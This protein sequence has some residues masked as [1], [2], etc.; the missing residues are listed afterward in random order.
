M[1]LVS[2]SAQFL[3]VSLSHRFNV[4]LRFALLIVFMLAVFPLVASAGPGNTLGFVQVDFSVPQTPQTSVTVAYTNAQTAGDLNVVV[5]GWN[6]STAKISSVTDSNGNAYVLAVG[7]TVQSGTATQAIYYAKN[8]AAAAANNNKVKVTF[9]MRA[10]FP[11]VRIAEY[12]G[13]DPTAPV[14]VV[15]AAQGTT[16]NSNSGS[17]TTTSPNDLLVGANLVQGITSGPGPGYT[18]RVITTQDGDILEDE[19]VTTVGSYSATAPN[20][21]AWIMQMV[22]FRAAGSGLGV[23]P[24][25]TSANNT[26]FAVGA[27]GTFTVTTMGTPTPSLTESGALPSG[28]TFK[29]NGNGTGT[30]SGTPASG[31]GG[32]YS[33]TFTASNG[34]GTPANQSFTLTV[35][36]VAAPSIANLSTTS[37]PVGTPV[38]IAGTNF[39]AAQ[40][41]STVTFNGTAATPTIWSPTSIVAPVPGGATTGNVVVTVGGQ[42]SN[43]LTFS[44]TTTSPGEPTLVQ[45]VSGSNTRDNALGSPYCYTQILPN[46][47][48]AGNAVIV[49]FTFN[50]SNVPLTP[51]VTDDKNNSYT[52]E[53]IFDGAT[54]GATSAQSIGLAAA[55][56]VTAGARVISVC[57]PSTPGFGGA[58]L[59]VMASEFSNVVG[60]DGSGTG[61]SSSGTSV[62]AGNLTPSV[63]DD[64]IYQITFSDSDNQSSF[65]AGSQSNITWNLLSADLKDGLAAQYGVYTSLATISPTM[66]MGTSQSFVSAAVLFTTGTAGSVPTGMR[67]VHLQH[68]SICGVA[69]CGSTFPNP[70]SL[71]FPSTGNLLVALSGGGNPACTMSSMTDSS[72]NSWVQAGSTYQ[73]SGG[74]G[75]DT[76]QIFYAGDAITSTGLN[77]TVNFSNGSCDWSILLYD[78]ANAAASPLDTTNGGTGNQGPTTGTLTVPYTITP[79]QSGELIFTDIIWDYNTAVGLSSDRGTSYFDANMFSGEPTNGPEPVDQNNGW[80]H[81]VSTST[82]AITFTWDQLINSRDS[83]PFAS[84]AAAFK[85]A[86][87]PAN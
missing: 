27:A 9:S 5:V 75:M 40:G 53:E 33:L 39:G 43:G 55:F 23:S 64:L 69:T 62:A 52:I 66:S 74:G 32:T 61:V 3:R 45:H 11:D 10:T 36:L 21:G 19:I 4:A 12:G 78:V 86:D 37:G 58:Y 7:P 60:I 84:M 18:S 79:A 38:T 72:S 26:T 44:V 42:A 76:V 2:G 1:D 71:Q 30:L 83:G 59:A 46:P 31:T 16:G 41:T 63:A 82:S 13:I 35:N 54:N 87:P 70:L 20:S 57:F 56:N 47:T 34:V 28:V 14:D 80:G 15:A 25:I 24:S 6:D 77:L 48:T 29:D 51:T 81:A 67:I 8:I 17:V 68:E 22:A 49:G 65:T 50:G 85:A 73:Y